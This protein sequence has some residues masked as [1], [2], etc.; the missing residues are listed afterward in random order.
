MFCVLAKRFPESSHT[1]QTGRK[2]SH[3]TQTRRKRGKTDILPIPTKGEV[4]LNS[5]ISV[6]TDKGDGSDTG[7]TASCGMMFGRGMLAYAVVW[8]RRRT[9]YT[10]LLNRYRFALPTAE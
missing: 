4:Y 8:E 6:N 3:A 2:R 9:L 10:G 7:K 5:T 1:A